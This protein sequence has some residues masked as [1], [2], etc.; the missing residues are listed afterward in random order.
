M[1]FKVN[2]SKPDDNYGDLADSGIYL[3]EIESAETRTGKV[4]GQEYIS[5]RMRCVD[6][7]KISVFDN[8]SS[9]LGA[10]GIVQ[11][12]LKA[13]GMDKVEEIE[14]GMFI[15]RRVRAGVKHEAGN[16]DVVRLV[17]DIKSPNSLAGY[18][19]ANPMEQVQKKDHFADFEDDIKF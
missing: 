18:Y 9:S 14:P 3:F 15:G 17:I 1:A 5:L 11:A 13:L 12:K 6:D 7:K 16:D 2:W 10:R 8:L 19:P 4:S